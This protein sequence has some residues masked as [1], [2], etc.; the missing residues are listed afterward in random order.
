MHFVNRTIHTYK[1]TSN[2]RKHT[3]YIYEYIHF[4][5]NAIMNNIYVIYGRDGITTT[6]MRISRR[7]LQNVPFLPDYID[8][9]RFLGQF[10]INFFSTKNCNLFP[11]QLLVLYN[12]KLKSS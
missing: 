5:D 11:A 7:N 1:N 3:L 2:T 6:A 10:E 4:F 12:F 9:N 8:F